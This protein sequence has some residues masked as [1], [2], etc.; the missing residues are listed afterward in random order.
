M[1][2]RDNVRPD[3]IIRR[4]LHSAQQEHFDGRFIGMMIGRVTDIN[5]PDRQRRIKVRLQFQQE[6]K[7]A[8]MQTGW[9]WRFTMFSGPTN[10]GRGRVFGDDWPMPEVGSLVGVFFNGGNVHDGYWF[11]QP[12]Y[13][14]G[15][16]GAPEL[17][18]DKHPDWSF[19]I[20][21]QNGWE[22]GI[23]TE[24]NEYKVTPGNYRHKIQCAAHISARGPMTMLSTKLRH[25]SLSVLRL[26]GVTIDQQNAPHPDEHGELREMQID[27][28]S[29]PPGRK[30]P[31]IGKITDIEG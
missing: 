17:E 23:D 14:E 4:G 10:M 28:M 1:N 2:Y 7:T 9:L 25:V 21:L 3:G 24:G 18:K 29:G 8:E 26:L 19:R 20:A 13:L 11:G 12:W 15:N 31:G 27:A 6:E 22:F 16:T 5:D 30:D